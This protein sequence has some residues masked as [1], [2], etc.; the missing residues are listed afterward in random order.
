MQKVLLRA[1]QHR[2]HKLDSSQK[3]RI[4]DYTVQ[5]EFLTYL[6]TDF[7]IQQLAGGEYIE[8]NK[9]VVSEGLGTLVTWGDH[10]VIVTHDHWSQIEK[11]E[12]VRIYDADGGLLWSLPAADFYSL[13]VYRDGGTM[14]FNAPVSLPGAI[15]L[16][17]DRKVQRDEILFLTY[18]Q[19]ET[20]NL[21]VVPVMVEDIIL[22]HDC[23]AFVLRSLNGAAVYTGNSG[24]GLWLDGQFVGTMWI[25]LVVQKVERKTLSVVISEEPTILSIAAKLP[26]S[27]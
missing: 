14:I 24:G 9:Y 21:D 25:T 17:F 20:G 8:R 19:P 6:S 27:P 22:Y 18:R 4:L 23:P 16:P 1:V 2:I 11:L 3:Y 15:Y 7:R 13:I 26:C 10:T 12:K 5:I